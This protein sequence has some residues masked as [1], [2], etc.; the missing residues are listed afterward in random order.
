MPFFFYHILQ[1]HFSVRKRTMPFSYLESRHFL[2]VTRPPLQYR[3]AS[4][5][6]GCLRGPFFNTSVAPFDLI[7]L[8]SRN[9]FHLSS[10]GP[11]IDLIFYHD[12]LESFPYFPQQISLS[13]LFL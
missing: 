8:L 6:A 12:R 1:P 11:S 4:P 3:L 7:D 2:G 10:C 5:L 9:F 13:F